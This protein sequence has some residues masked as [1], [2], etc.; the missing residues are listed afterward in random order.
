MLRKERNIR[1][2]SV[3]SLS[4]K[5]VHYIML[6][7]L[8]LLSFCCLYPFL[9]ILSSSFQPQE[10]ILNDGYRVFAR[11]YTLETYKMIFTDPSKLLDSYVVTI[12]TTAATVVLGVTVTSAY[13]YVLSRKDYKYRRFLAVY[14]FFTTLFGGGLPA[15]YILI[16]RWLHMKDSIWV[17]ILPLCCGAGHII[18]FKAF[19][20]SISTEI[21]ESAKLDGA[22]EMRIFSSIIVPMSKPAVATISV[23]LTLGTWNEYFSCMLYTENEKLHKLQY[24]LMK[25]LNNIEFM[26]SPEYMQYVG[27]GGLGTLDIPTYG[28]RMAMCVLAAGPIVLI[29]PFFQKYFV[30]GI[31]I[32]GIKG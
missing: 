1:H 30:K 11:E 2:G 20:S 16:T 21:I 15:T 18:M 10:V 32:G 14:A 8:C 31:N 28:A 29:F 7:I 6:V 24:L 22:S 19:F 17:L 12:G 4:D 13:G 3:R 9:L 26:N 25:L 23:M 27:A 5:A